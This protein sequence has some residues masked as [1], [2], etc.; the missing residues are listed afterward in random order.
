ME[1]L[2]TYSGKQVTSFIQDP[3]TWLFMTY[4]SMPYLKRESVKN[5]Y[6]CFKKM[7]K[8]NFIFEHDFY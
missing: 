7:W 2:N 8:E 3:Q 5:I 4:G 6:F 1:S